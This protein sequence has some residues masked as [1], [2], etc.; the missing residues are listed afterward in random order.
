MTSDDASRPTG[1]DVG[2]RL[3]AAASTDGDA[4]PVGN[5]ETEETGFPH[6]EQNCAA[7]GREEPH[8]GQ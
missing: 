1:A 3:R 5:W 4:R 2:L 6:A 8:F 7:A